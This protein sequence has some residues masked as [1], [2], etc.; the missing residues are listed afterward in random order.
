M[1]KGQPVFVAINRKANTYRLLCEALNGVWKGAVRLPR[2]MEVLRNSPRALVIAVD[3]GSFAI[4][5]D[6]LVIL[7]L[8]PLKLVRPFLIPAKRVLSLELRRKTTHL[9]VFALC[10]STRTVTVQEA[11]VLNRRRPLPPGIHH[12]AAL[13]RTDHPRIVQ[14]GLPSLGKRN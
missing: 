3:R 9:D 6:A 1:F 10:Q 14:G 13:T 4:E 7:T 2:G 5:H 12:E 11:R 8:P